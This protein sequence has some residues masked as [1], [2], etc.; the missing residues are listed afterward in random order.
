MR[1][2]AAADSGWLVR[3]ESD[4]SPEPSSV[5]TKPSDTTTTAPH[6]ART[7]PGRRVAYAASRLGPNRDPEAA[8]SGGPFG[9]EIDIPAPDTCV[10][11]TEPRG[12]ET[13]TP[14]E[15]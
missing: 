6:T 5:P 7:R 15:S 4:V 2:C 1:S 10:R 11:A 13:P 8:R 14:A 12:S 3:L 9:E